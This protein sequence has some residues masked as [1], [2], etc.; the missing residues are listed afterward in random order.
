MQ[1]LENKIGAKTMAKL[2]EAFKTPGATAD[3][4]ETL[5]GVER[6]RVAKLLANP[7]GWVQE[8]AGGATAGATNALAPTQQN[9]NA[10]AP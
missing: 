6:N 2:T 10:L 9:Q 8:S 7:K 1:I 5:P 4:L 3:L